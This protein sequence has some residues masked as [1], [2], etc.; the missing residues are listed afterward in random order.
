MF[1]KIPP[2]SPAFLD[3]PNLGFWSYGQEKLFCDNK[4]VES[5]IKSSLTDR[6]GRKAAKLTEI[7]ANK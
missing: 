3:S 6:I 2:R 1:P 4:V 5:A 7:I